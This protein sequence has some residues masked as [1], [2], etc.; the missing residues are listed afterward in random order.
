[1]F[2]RFRDLAEIIEQQD[3][4]EGRGELKLQI[5]MYAYHDGGHILMILGITRH[6]SL[7]MKIAQRYKPSL[8]PI[9]STRRSNPFA[10]FITLEL[11]YHKGGD[12]MGS[13]RYI[14]PVV[15]VISE[16][17]IRSCLNTL[18]FLHKKKETLN[19]VISLSFDLLLPDLVVGTYYAAVIEN[20]TNFVGRVVVV[21]VGAGSGILSLFAALVVY[22]GAK[23]VYAVETSEMLAYACKLTVVTTIDHLSTKLWFESILPHLLQ[24]RLS[25][26]VPPAMCEDCY[27]RV[28]NEFMKQSKGVADQVCLSLLPTSEGSSVTVARA[29]SIF[30]TWKHC[31]GALMQKLIKHN[32]PLKSGYMDAFTESREKAMVVN[33]E[34][35]KAIV[36]AE[37]VLLLDPLFQEVLPFVDQLQ[38][39]LPHK[40]VSKSQRGGQMDVQDNEMQL[41]SGGQWLPIP[42]AVEGLK[43]DLP[44]EFQVL[45]IALKVVCTYLDSSVA[46]L[47]RNAYSVLDEL[48]R[49]VSTKNFERVRSLKSNLTSLLARVQKWLFGKMNPMSFGEERSIEVEQRV[50]IIYKLVCTTFVLLDANI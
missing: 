1:M 37:E 41:S 47:E 30:H 34:F 40:S 19:M 25:V 31:G 45:K 5:N 17:D 49:N 32:Q 14:C 7:E 2:R 42:E 16:C 50:E 36:T 43:C 6:G 48:V 46:D 26:E 27:K 22:V 10:A 33:L 12:L 15:I 3:E 28:M 35:I 4:R 44:F 18:Q 39:Q 38:Q 24:I 11:L 23:H 13:R 20:C 9:G 21:D 29:L 8:S